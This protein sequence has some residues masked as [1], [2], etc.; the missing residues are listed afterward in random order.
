MALSGRPEKI[1]ESK[2]SFF[3][4]FALVFSLMEPLTN[5][6]YTGAVGFVS[7]QQTG[8][9]YMSR[10]F[11]IG[12]HVGHIVD[13]SGKHDVPTLGG[14][15]VD[16]YFDAFQHVDDCRQFAFLNLRA[17]S[18]RSSGVPVSL[19]VTMC[20]TITAISFISCTIVRGRPVPSRR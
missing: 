13:D 20:F 18:L 15:F 9:G 16:T 14:V 8:S 4:M 17:T 7:G 2:S 5:I 12:F 6:I 1:Y 3:A 19:K 10:V 11:G